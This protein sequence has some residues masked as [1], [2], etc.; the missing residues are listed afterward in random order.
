MCCFASMYAEELKRIDAYKNALH[1]Q[2]GRQGGV[3][4][5]EEHYWRYLAFVAA[6][7]D[8]AGYLRLLDEPLSDVYLVY[9]YR[10]LDG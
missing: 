2:Q 10:Q 4:L 7:G 8:A 6:A 1:V 5:P 3:A 9:L